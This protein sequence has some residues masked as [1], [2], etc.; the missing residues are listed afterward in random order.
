LEGNSAN[1][2][3]SNANSLYGPVHPVVNL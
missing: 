1:K 2:S 3:E